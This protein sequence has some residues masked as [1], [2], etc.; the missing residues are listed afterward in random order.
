[1][2][3]PDCHVVRAFS[4]LS[5][6]DWKGNFLPSRGYVKVL[7]VIGVLSSRLPDLEFVLLSKQVDETLCVRLLNTVTGRNSVRRVVFVDR[8]H[9]L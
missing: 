4:S 2:N 6:G 7:E 3:I 8:G 5:Q 9:P 1:M